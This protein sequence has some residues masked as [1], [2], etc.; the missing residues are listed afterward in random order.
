MA[1]ETINIELTVN[2]STPPPTPF[3]VV[4][5]SGNVLS[6]GSTIGLT[7]DT[8]GVADAGQVMFSASGG[9]APYTIAIASGATLPDGY[10]VNS[11]DNSDGSVTYSIAGT[12]TTA[13]SY[14]FGLLVSDSAGASA[15]I[16]VSS[17]KSTTKKKLFSGF[18]V[19]SK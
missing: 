13:G 18:G 4:D 5:A 11:E 3:T 10:E 2:P 12:P 9:T 17:T 6:D 7:N 8:V 19:K 15:N 1:D 14:A 16:G